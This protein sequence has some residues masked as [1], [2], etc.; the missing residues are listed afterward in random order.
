METVAQI[1]QRKG[2]QVWSV[3]A[4][5]TVLDAV[6]L[7]AEKNIGAVLVMDGQ[8]VVGIFS[9]RDF[10]RRVGAQQRDPATTP[11]REVMTT[12]VLSISPKATVEDCLAVMTEKRL[13]HLPVVEADR[14]V[15]VVS[16]GDAVKAA[17]EHREF[18]IQQL[19]NY[20]TGERA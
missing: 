6:R 15:G 14:V 19:V 9:E 5:A 3:A 10:V 4:G 18:T 12:K 16:I 11:I 8:R 7:M 17:L 2:H 13:R 1:L 20:I